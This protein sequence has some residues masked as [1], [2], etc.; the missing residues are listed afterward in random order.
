MADGSNGFVGF[1]KMLN[2]RDRL[3]IQVD[4]LRGTT[5]GNYQGV[6]AGDIHLEKEGIES[7]IVP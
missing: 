5:A 6:V 4:I 7:E 3:R 1:R 2:R